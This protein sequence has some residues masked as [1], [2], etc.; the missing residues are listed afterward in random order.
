M[1]KSAPALAESISE[2]LKRVPSGLAGF[3]A[4]RRARFAEAAFLEP[5]SLRKIPPHPITAAILLL[6][7]D[8]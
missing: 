7:T 3:L 1:R 5:L 6:R 2:R 8:L 4:H